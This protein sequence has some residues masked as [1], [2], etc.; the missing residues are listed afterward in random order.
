M[1]IIKQTPS[2]TLKMTRSFDLGFFRKAR[3]ICCRRWYQDKN[4]IDKA[5]KNFPDFMPFFQIHIV[6]MKRYDKIKLNWT[7]YP[8]SVNI[9]S[10]IAIGR[11]YGNPMINISNMF[12]ENIIDSRN[13]GVQWMKTRTEE[14]FKAF[15]CDAELLLRCPE[16]TLERPFNLT[17][18]AIF[19]W[20]PWASK[21]FSDCIV[22]KF[23]I[24]CLSCD[25]PWLINALIQ[26]D[27]R[28]N[29]FCY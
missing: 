28:W 21:S 17:C 3:H 27:M 1:T 5:A 6:K 14:K 29:H 12:R 7:L 20:D 15:F 24:L 2:Q 22:T 11:T 8:A 18:S 9:S 26:L 10:W 16:I 13:A 4:L 19:S 25:S 23:E